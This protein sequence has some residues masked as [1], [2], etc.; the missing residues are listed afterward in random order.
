MSQDA[1]LSRLRRGVPQIWINPKQM[2]T[3]DVLPKL[4]LRYEDILDAESRLERFA[5][6]LA[7]LFPELAD[8]RGIIESELRAIPAMA[9]WMSTQVRGHLPGQM[10]IKTDGNLPVAGSVKA[11]GGIYAVL[12][13]AENL[14]GQKGLLSPGDDRRDL[15]AARVQKMF[16]RYTISVGST[17]NRGL[18]IGITAA[19]LG[20]KAVVHMSR[21]AKNWKKSICAPTG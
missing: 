8:S 16:R 19:A 3:V 9:T 11:R 15:A 1:T 2:G 17:G 20:F 10:L 6:L 18:S 13:Y 4:P 21:E 5:P 14:A 12:L 7:D